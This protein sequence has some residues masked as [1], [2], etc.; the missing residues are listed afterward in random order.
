MLGHR[1]QRWSNIKPAWLLRL[2]FA[3]LNVALRYSCPAG[4][5]SQRGDR[6]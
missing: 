2:L 6:L 5:T 1:L 3:G 4:Y